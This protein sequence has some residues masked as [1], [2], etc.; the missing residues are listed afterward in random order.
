MSQTA[1]NTDYAALNKVA[2][3][4]RLIIGAIVAL[5]AGGL[6]LYVFRNKPNAMIEIAVTIVEVLA[7][8]V[9]IYG[10]FKIAAG[11]KYSIISRVIIAALILAP[12]AAGIAAEAGLHWSPD[13]G[14][15]QTL[16]V[17]SLINIFVVLY[18]LNAANKA[19]KK[20]GYKVGFFGADPIKA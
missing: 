1:A 2:F 14:I 8:L 5:I 6:T 16:V 17:V 7:R 9:A 13:S 4:Q 10:F 15:E 18:L 3:G 12:T 19:L 20:A 11:L